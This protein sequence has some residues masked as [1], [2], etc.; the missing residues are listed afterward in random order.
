MAD[1]VVIEDVVMLFEGREKRIEEH[2][3]MKLIMSSQVASCESEV[4]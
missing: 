4:K 1:V 3:N 2:G